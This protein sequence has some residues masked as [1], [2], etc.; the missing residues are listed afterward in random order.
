MSVIDPRGLTVMDWTD[1][2]ALLLRDNTSAMKLQDPEKWREWASN[3][4]GDPDFVGQN[5]PDPFQFDDW[6]EWAMRFNSTVELT[7]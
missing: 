6:R 7:G 3:L 2:M 1:S 4:I 5:T